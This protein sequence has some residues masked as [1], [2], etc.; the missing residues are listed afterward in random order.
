M[1]RDSLIARLMRSKRWI[2]AL[3]L[4]AKL[5]QALGQDSY[6]TAQGYIGWIDQ[7]EKKLNSAFSS[8]PPLEDTRDHLSAQLELMYLTF[9]TADIA[10]GYIRLQKAAPNFLH[11]VATDPTLYSEHP[12]GNLFVSLPRTL[13]VPRNELKRFLM[14][15]TVTALVLGVPPLVEYGY[16]GECDLASHGLEW[17]HGTPLTLVQAVAQVNS[18][19]AGS[20]VP[21]DDW[22]T[23]EGRVLAWEPGPIVPDDEESGTGSVARLAVQESWRHAALIYIYMARN[24]WSFISGFACAVV[25][26][27]DSSA[28]GNCSQPADWYTSVPPL[29]YC[30]CRSEV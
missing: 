4:G 21:L 10:P 2:W 19:R 30:R 27:T 22:E 7:F 5:L 29:C 6:G 28:R 24:V 15:D 11:L 26:S 17:I 9:L 25:S 13:S 16:D 20:R 1:I 12:D 23:L 8:N 18:W 14:Y 3:F